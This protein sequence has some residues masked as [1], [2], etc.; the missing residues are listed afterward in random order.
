MRRRMNAKF[1]A[2]LLVGFSFCIGASCQIYDEIQTKRENVRKRLTEVCNSFTPTSTMQKVGTQEVIKPTLG[3]YTNIYETSSSCADLKS[4]FY[5]QLIS[6]KWEP[7]KP[8]S[9]YYYQE[10][11][12]VSIMCETGVPRENSQT[13][14]VIC[15]WDSNG[16]NKEVLK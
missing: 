4:H 6:R 5:D 8:E 7:V 1:V 13:A 11:Y 16:V 9:A 10:N 14:R 3:S 2:L 15:S 12:V